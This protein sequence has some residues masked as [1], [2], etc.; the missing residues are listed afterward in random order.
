MDREGN[1][2]CPDSI[3][4]KDAKVGLSN[5]DGRVENGHYSPRLSIGGQVPSLPGS[6]GRLVQVAEAEREYSA[7]PDPAI[8]KA[9]GTDSDRELLWSRSHHRRRNFQMN[10]NVTDKRE[11][12]MLPDEF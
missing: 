12:G 6:C 7:L 3:P 1:A 4:E 9:C 11:H 2:L 5:I 10:G 8:S